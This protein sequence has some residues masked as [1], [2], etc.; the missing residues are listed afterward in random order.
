M[1]AGVPSW[2]SGTGLHVCAI[3][4]PSVGRDLARWTRFGSCEK[5][6]R[7]S[8][9]MKRLRDNVLEMPVGFCLNLLST[10]ERL[11]IQRALHLYGLVGPDHQS[12]RDASRSWHCS[13]RP[14]RPRDTASGRRRV[15]PK[16]PWFYCAPSLSVEAPPGASPP[17]KRHL[18]SVAGR[19]TTIRP[20]RAQ[21]ACT[22][23]C[24]RQ[25]HAA[26]ISAARQRCQCARAPSGAHY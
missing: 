10:G 5:L 7:L 2:G 21:P 12:L 16:M 1:C 18:G 19:P 3:S 22:G 15:A 9:K 25:R 23:P 17:S 11:Q 20:S 6:E 13:W 24:C 26:R 8:F 4:V 14:S